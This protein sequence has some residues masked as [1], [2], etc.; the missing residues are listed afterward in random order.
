MYDKQKYFISVLVVFFLF[1]GFLWLKINYQKIEII[2]YSFDDENSYVELKSVIKDHPRLPHPDTEFLKA[3]QKEEKAFNKYIKLANEFNPDSIRKES[4]ISLLVA[5]LCTKNENYLHQIKALATNQFSNW[6]FSRLEVISVA[7]DWTYEYL[8]EDSKVLFQN[9][10]ER[11]CN[12]WMKYYKDNRISPYNDIGYIRLKA[13]IFLGALSICHEI[14]NGNKLLQFAHD[15]LFDKY[16]PVWKQIMKGGGWHEGAEYFR[17]GVGQII[18]S[19]L[20]SWGSATERNYFMENKWLE[21]LIFYGIYTQRPDAQAI[22]IGDVARGGSALFPDLLP[23][24][25]I[26]N[27]PYGKCFHR[28]YALYGTGAPSDYEP[29]GW[30]W[31]KPDSPKALVKPPDDLPLDHFFEGW[32][33]VT[34]RSGWSEDDVFATFKAGDHFWSHQHCDSGSFTIYKRGALAIDSGT[35]MAGYN[36]DHHLKYQMQTIA[37]NCIT[38]TDPKDY[39]PKEKIVLPNDGGQRRIKEI[40]PNDIGQWMGKKENYEMGDIVRVDLNK[41][42]SYIAADITAAYNNSMSGKGDYGNR[43]DRVKACERQFLFIKPNIFLIVDYVVSK[44]AKYKKKWLLHS[45]NKPLIKEKSIEVIRA[46]KVKHRYSWPTYLKYRQLDKVHYQYNGKLVVQPLLPIERRIRLIGGP[47]HEFEIDGVNYNTDSKGA[48]IKPDSTTGPQEPGSWRIEISP[49]ENRKEDLFLN[50]LVALDSTEK[51]KS[52]VSVLSNRNDGKFIWL[53]ICDN[54]N[55]KVVILPKKIMSYEKF[56]SIEIPFIVKKYDMSFYLFGADPNSYYSVQ[57][58]GNNITIKKMNSEETN[59]FS[60]E[61]G[62]LIL[63]FTTVQF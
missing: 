23:L 10:I 47:G 34:M 21:D 29:S 37:H 22:K 14:D 54:K 32:G 46:E 59:L 52:Y 18:V 25:I 7:Y 48:I 24:S 61:S 43:T 20:S 44:N 15:V 8:D 5:F 63:D 3:L 27:N 28:K 2:G 56:D 50:A 13:G 26:Y 62:T 51:N 38:V 60:N 49:G 42:Y 19:S 41:D 16:L 31:V 45:I 30:P 4:V 58:T 35:Y 1:S 57:R 33:V 39:Y 55:R 12:Q 36:S 9:R 11:E 53:L 17:L 40:S 6:W